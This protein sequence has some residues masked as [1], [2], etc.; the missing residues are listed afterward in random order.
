MFTVSRVGPFSDALHAL[1]RATPCGSGPFRNGVDGGGGRALL[2]GGG[3]GA[4]PLY[5][6]ARAFG[7]SA[8]A[9]VEV[10]LG[11]RTSPDLLFV[12]PLCRPRRARP[13]RQRKTAPRERTGQVTAIVAPL[14]GS[15]RFDRLCACGPEGMLA[16][17]EALCG[18]CGCPRELS[19]RRTCAAGWASA[20][21]ASTRTGW[22]AW[23]G[24]CSRFPG[25]IALCHQVATTE[26]SLSS[27]ALGDASRNQA[28]RPGANDEDHRAANPAPLG[29]LKSSLLTC[30]HSTV[31]GFV[32]Y[33][34][35]R[36]AS[37]FRRRLLIMGSLSPLAE[38]VVEVL[39]QQ[40]ILDVV[41]PQR[42][43]PEQ[44]GIVSAVVT[45]FAVEKRKGFD[46][47]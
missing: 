43:S 34:L 16:A 4:A 37:A 19:S 21:P 11:A 29:V 5:F 14:L 30:E 33:T 27:S 42:Q 8:G 45:C 39:S 2:V 32:E 31:A 46:S 6:L 10:A 3:Y 18:A 22:C 47:S 7:R 12:R 24:R 38:L 9:G 35:S 23:T 17:L 41:V 44:H 1:S 13:A 36:N 40:T 20:A 15:G 26:P 28:R 25:T